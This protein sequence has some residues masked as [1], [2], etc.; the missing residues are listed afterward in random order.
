MERRNITRCA[1]LSQASS[2]L[3]R[4]KMRMSG[5]CKVEMSAFIGGRGRYGNGANRLEPTR[6][7]PAAGATRGQAE[8]DHADRSRQ[9]AKDQRSPH[10]STAISSGGTRRSSG[11]P[12]ITRKTIKPQ[13]N[14]AVG[15]ED[16]EPGAPT[17]CGLR[18]HPGR[19]APGPGGIA[20]EPR[21]AAEVD[22]E[23]QSVAPTRATRKNH[24]CV[25]GT[26]SPFRRTA[27]AG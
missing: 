1:R 16:F 4:C 15:A 7:G 12:W 10:P 14:Y 23:G 9:A 22:G 6:T 17:L 19:R 18:T 8:A 2:K 27:D 5:L 26:A 24:P 20:G 3:C 21:D 13:V 25:A 11:D